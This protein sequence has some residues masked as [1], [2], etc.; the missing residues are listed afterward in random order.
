MR[1]EN[2][3]LGVETITRRDRTARSATKPRSSS[4]IDQWR[5]VRPER[6]RLEKIQRAGPRMG[7]SS[8][9]DGL[10][11]FLE[12]LAGLRP[13]GQGHFDQDQWE[14]YHVDVDFFH[15]RERAVLARR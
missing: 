1:V 9:G 4:S 15:C 12:E 10:Y 6:T 5:T 7:S 13:T 2:A 11:P 3:R 8:R 14:L